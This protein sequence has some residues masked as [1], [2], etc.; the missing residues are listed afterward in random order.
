MDNSLQE[1]NQ[2]S[3]LDKELLEK[4]D[5]LEELLNKVMDDELKK[6]S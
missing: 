2:I 4:Q 5:L 3:E 6:T 1:K